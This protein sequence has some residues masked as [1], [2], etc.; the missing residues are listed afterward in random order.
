MTPRYAV[1]SRSHFC[2]A[3]ISPSP[4][5]RRPGATST[6]CLSARRRRRPAASSP[7]RASLTSHRPLRS[8]AD[9]GR[10]SA[11]SAATPARPV[12]RSPVSTRSGPAARRRW[13]CTP[14]SRPPWPRAAPARR[15]RRTR[16]TRPRSAA[17]A[18]GPRGW[19][20][21]PPPPGAAAQ[22]SCSSGS[23]RSG[24]STTS[25]STLP[26][27]TSSTTSQRASPG[28]GA[29]T[30]RLLDTSFVDV[31]PDPGPDGDWTAPGAYEVHPG[32]HRMPLPLPNDG[33]RA[34]NVY[35]LAADD[36]LILVDS[37][38]AIRA[39]REALDTALGALG[40]TLADVR[41]FLV[42]HVHRDHYTQAIYVRREFGTSVSLGAGD[43][44]SL[45]IVM[46]PARA[47]LKEQLQHLRLLGASELVDKLIAAL[48]P[49]HDPVKAGW[50][51]PDVWLHGGER[52]DAGELSLEA[53]PTPGHTQ[54][55]MVFHD[56][57]N[58]LLFAG[59]HVLPTIPP[60]IGFEPVLSPN[61]LGDFLESLASVRARPDARLLP[62][63][64][65]VTDSVH[66]RVDELVAHHGK[67]LDETLAAIARG[68][69]SAY[70]VATQL[71]W[72]RR[73]RTLDE[74]DP[75]NQMLAIAE[76][77]A[78]LELLAAQ[79]RVTYDDVDGLRCY[80]AA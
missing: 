58:G 19:R 36:G 7:T 27:A 57:N 15:G 63:H 4:R 55:H 38:W 49:D 16:V 72:T 42:T 64:G 68:A 32:V 70:D 40:H 1:T 30:D 79:G 69:V 18:R 75:F 74:L 59:A 50:E 37:G 25:T 17:V 60:S 5:E 31:A 11:C 43:R 54:G 65:A 80:R 71:S 14:T 39:A 45:D 33:L 23:A 9:P 6:T 78:H 24:G 26:S 22:P 73:E 67:R 46:T 66:K 3:A 77:A 56:S 21:P 62:A 76:T 8:S 44:G 53:V 20:S 29:T 51:L 52:I 10:A 28:G 13:G 35:A 41:R 12:C 61:P 34:V 2:S 47:P 48:G